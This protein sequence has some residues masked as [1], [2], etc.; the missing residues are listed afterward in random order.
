[1]TAEWEPHETSGHDLHHAAAVRSR[2][3]GWVGAVVIGIAILMVAFAAGAQWLTASRWDP[4]GDYP[5]QT[6][7][8]GVNLPATPSP[9]S[10]AGG[11]T[12]TGPPTFYIDQSIS[13]FGTKCVKPGEGIQPDEVAPTTTASTTTTVPGAST[14][15]LTI[16]PTVP[17]TPPLVAGT[18]QVKGTLSW[19]SDNP[20][21]R[22]IEVRSGGGIR[23]PGCVS[24]T[25]RN[26]IP[27][28]V[29][30]EILRL[31][32][33]GIYQSDWHLTGTEVPVRTVDGVEERGEPRTWVSTTFRVLPVEAP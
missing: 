33:E 15:S 21:G 5:L 3:W 25:F 28:E 31:A 13:V 9:T 27:E 6:V 24:S 2:A 17:H 30:R 10:L 14:T 20:L 11:S 16:P 7:F 19:V 1:V 23:G 4:L 18:V 32:D 8:T 22:I 26:P 12:G 29:Q